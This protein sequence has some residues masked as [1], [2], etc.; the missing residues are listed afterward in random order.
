LREDIGESKNVIP[1][2]SEI[3]KRLAA[4]LEDQLSGLEN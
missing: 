2:H 4:A 1:D 3:A